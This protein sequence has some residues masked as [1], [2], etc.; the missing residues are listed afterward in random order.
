MKTITLILS[1]LLL[2]TG[3]GTVPAGKMSK[4]T[5]DYQAVSRGYYLNILMNGRDVVIRDKREGPDK[6]V[7]LTDSELKEFGLLFDKIPA[8]QLPAYKGP[9]QKRFYDGAAIATLSITE[10]GTTYITEGFDHGDP[11]LEIATFVNKIVAL[12]TR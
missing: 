3:C 9:T 7:T 2:A 8:D 1:L 4:A 12:S 11:P 10:N 5:V 6:K